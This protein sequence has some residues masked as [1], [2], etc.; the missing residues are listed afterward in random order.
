MMT[1]TMVHAD[2]GYSLRDEKLSLAAP[3]V[4]VHWPVTGVVVL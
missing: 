4:Q 1:M 2:E 3:M